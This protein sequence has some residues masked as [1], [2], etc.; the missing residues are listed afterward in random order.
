MKDFF[1]YVLATVVG[2]IL[3]SIIVLILGAMSLVGMVASGE[4]TKNVSKNSVLVMNLSGSMEEQAG[5]NTLTQFF[6]SVAGSMGLQQTLEAISK[7][8]DNENVKGIYME[9]GAF[10]SDY[11]SLQEVRNA[12]L[13]F[14][15]SGKWVVAYGDTYTQGTYYLCSVA[16]K[17]WMN[18]SGEIDWHGIASEP[19][20]VKD[21]LA[22]VGIKMQVIKVG[23][24]KSATEMYTEDHQHEP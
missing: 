4:A 19:M 13:D 14:K 10:S 12:L 17:V 23:K 2:I 5:D 21:L 3:F 16:D 7:A 18:P 20:F 9:A 6:G 22:K 1:K 24:Y 8:K 11:A 15:K